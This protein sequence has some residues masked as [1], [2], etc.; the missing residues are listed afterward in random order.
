V[1]DGKSVIS[2]GVFPYRWK[3]GKTQKSLG[4]IPHASGI[5][6]T[7]RSAKADLKRILS[8]KML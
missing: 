7:V 6:L 4:E 3:W 1:F 8:E 2:A 5:H